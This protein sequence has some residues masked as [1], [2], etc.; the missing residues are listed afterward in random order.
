M[1]APRVVPEIAMCPNTAGTYF[2]FESFWRQVFSYLFTPRSVYTY[3]QLVTSVGVFL[4]DESYL[5]SRVSAF[6]FEGR[7]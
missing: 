7:I 2:R 1:N 3:I 5:P 6:F 4:M